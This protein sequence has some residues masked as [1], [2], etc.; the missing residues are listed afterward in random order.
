MACKREK[1][2]AKKRRRRWFW[3]GREHKDNDDEIIFNFREA[4]MAQKKMRDC[5]KNKFIHECDANK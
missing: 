5:F 3:N 4:G 1:A 2:N